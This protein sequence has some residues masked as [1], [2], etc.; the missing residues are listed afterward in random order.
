MNNNPIEKHV[1]KPPKISKDARAT[2]KLCYISRN[3]AKLS[4]TIPTMNNTEGKD[5]KLS[6]NLKVQ[7]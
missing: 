1:Y 7:R 6:S 3:V 4:E 2:E 5:P